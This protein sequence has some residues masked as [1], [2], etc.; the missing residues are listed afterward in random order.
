MFNTAS[1]IYDCHSEGYCFVLIIYLKNVY[2]TFIYVI[3]CSVFYVPLVGLDKNK[4]L[5]LELNQRLKTLVLQ[6]LYLI[7]GIEGK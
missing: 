5:E 1:I 3:N 6:L 7:L 2:V 4:K